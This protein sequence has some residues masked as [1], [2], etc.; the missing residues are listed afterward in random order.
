MCSDADRLGF[1]NKL[2]EHVKDTCPKRSIVFTSLSKKG[3][4]KY[5]SDCFLPLVGKV[6]EEVTLLVDVD[7][8][9]P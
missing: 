9:G 7:V 2:I 8:H 1:T 6:A 4:D 3:Q 5:Y